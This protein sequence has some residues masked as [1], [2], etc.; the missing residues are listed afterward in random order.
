MTFLSGTAGVRLADMLTRFAA[1]L[2][3]GRNGGSRC[4]LRDCGKQRQ[5]RTM[6]KNNGDAQENTTAGSDVP[7]GAEALLARAE[8]IL[9]QAKKSNVRISSAESCTGGLLSSLLT[10]IEGYSGLFERGFATYSNEAKAELLG[11]DPIMIARHGAVSGAVATAMAKGALDN[12]RAGIAVAITGFAGPGG[13]RDEEGLVHIAA[14]S[15]SGALIHRECH[16]GPRGR[17]EVRL[18]AA[19]GALDL[20][21][22]LLDEQA[23]PLSD[24]SGGTDG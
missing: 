17:Q 16:F 1:D 6:S 2:G 5:F 19:G 3:G 9:R 18:L 7:D 8:Q 4:P 21:A 14:A 23:K 20:L 22:E 10:D 11:V 12:S 15:R 13:K 24:G